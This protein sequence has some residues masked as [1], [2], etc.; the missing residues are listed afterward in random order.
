MFY[1]AN[2][3]SSYDIKTKFNNIDLWTKS[4]ATVPKFKEE[5]IVKI[6]LSKVWKSQA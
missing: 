6:I 3:R 5:F 2:F 1:R 4:A